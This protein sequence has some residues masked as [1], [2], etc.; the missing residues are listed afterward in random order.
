MERKAARVKV[1]M[2]ETKVCQVSKASL[3]NENIGTRKTLDE[4]TLYLD[5]CSTYSSCFVKKFLD[6]NR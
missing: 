1:N 2:R 6:H 3:S 5:S 4:H